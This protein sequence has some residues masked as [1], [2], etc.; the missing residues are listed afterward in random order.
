MRCLTAASA[1]A[2]NKRDSKKQRQEAVASNDDDGKGSKKAAGALKTHIAHE[3]ADLSDLVQF[4]PESVL[5][6]NVGKPSVFPRNTYDQLKT[7]GL[8]RRVDKELSGLSPSSVIRQATLDIVRTLEGAKTKDSKDARYILSG[9]KGSGKSMLLL[10]AVSHAIESSWIVLYDPSAAKWVNS[11]SQFEYNA[12]SKTFHQPELASTLLSKL[13]AVNRDRLANITLPADVKFKTQTLKKGSKLVDLVALGVKDSR[14]SVQALE[15]TLSTLAS[16]TQFPVLLAIDDIQAIF[17]E[18]HYRAP[19]Y[20][21][22]QSYQLSTP[23]LILDFMSGTKS[24]KKGAVITSIS[25]SDTQFLPPNEL[26]MGIG[27]PTRSQVHAYSKLDE[28]ALAYAKSGLQR[29]DVPFG[30]SGPEAAAM[31][32]LWSRKGWAS[33]G[34]D[35]VFLS[36]W[37]AA[38]GN[39]RELARAWTRSHYSYIV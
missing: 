3:P 35:E 8:P 32:E 10:Q 38:A 18:S 21:K 16:Q 7:F 9:Q 12:E 36:G 11:S 27:A 33:N 39:P 20:S 29:I 19:D 30:M 14:S 31:F 17:S 24:F 23:R 4:Y 28:T 1:S 13:L 26:L 15:A 25:D 5:P 2:Q 22:I 34:S 37:N 6:L